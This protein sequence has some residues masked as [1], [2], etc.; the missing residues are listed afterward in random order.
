MRKELKKAIIEWLFDNPKE[1]CRVIKCMQAFRPYIFDG[2]GSY[3]IGG[4]E[5]AEFIT[6]ADEL[7]NNKFNL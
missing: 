2:N 5:V 6:Q 1:F 4:E 7:I 3:L